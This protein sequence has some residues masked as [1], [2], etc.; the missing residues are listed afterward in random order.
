ML[1]RVLSVQERN[2]R[3]TLFTMPGTDPLLVQRSMDVEQGAVL[4]KLE[5]EQM[6][7]E[8]A[9]DRDFQPPAKKVR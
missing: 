1:S 4:R 7:G 3:I 6:R 8:R 5:R 2:S 9:D